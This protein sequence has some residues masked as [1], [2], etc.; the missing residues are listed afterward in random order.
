MSRHASAELQAGAGASSALSRAF[1]IGEAT[2]RVT[3]GT[4]LKS[5]ELS[6]KQR[7]VGARRHGE[8]SL[9]NHIIL[10]LCLSM[11]TVALKQL[12]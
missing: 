5:F 4:E 8:E 12:D 6:T 10:G 9:L 3:G 7:P 11:K 1:T 2:C